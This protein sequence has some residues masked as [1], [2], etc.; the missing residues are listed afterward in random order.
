M[1]LSVRRHG[2]RDSEIYCYNIEG[3]RNSVVKQAPCRMDVTRLEQVPTAV[4]G[5][6]VGLIFRSMST[7]IV[8]FKLLVHVV[9]YDK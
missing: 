6:F 3:D 7:K 9:I 2:S 1:A 4:C 8:F 5:R